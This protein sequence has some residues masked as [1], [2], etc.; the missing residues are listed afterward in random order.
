M[1]CCS[2]CQVVDILTYFLYTLIFYFFLQ[3][4]QIHQWWKARLKMLILRSLSMLMLVTYIY[5]TEKEDVRAGM[6][7]LC[8][9][10]NII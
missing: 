5:S 9:F 6:H 8:L 3:E 10:S 4:G 1:L 7:Q 2:V